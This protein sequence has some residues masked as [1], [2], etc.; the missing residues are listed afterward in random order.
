MSLSIPKKSTFTRI[1]KPSLA[2]A[3]GRS[4]RYTFLMPEFETQVRVRYA[5]TDQMGVVYHANYLIW[6]DITRVE[7]CDHVGFDYRE[8][9]QEGVVIAVIEARCRYIYPARFNDI[10]RIQL[11]VLETTAKS[12]RFGYEMLRAADGRR[13]ATA[14]SSHLYLNRT[15]FR[16][17]RLP[18]RYHDAFRVSDAS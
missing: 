16:P 3:A 12:L 7:F 15:N 1:A 5:E 17:T 9:E 18:E 2:D 14:E 6:M 4:L 8:M 10:I 11:T 13:V